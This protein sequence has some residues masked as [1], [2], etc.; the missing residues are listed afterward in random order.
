MNAFLTTAFALLSPIAAHACVDVSGT[1]LMGDIIAIH[2]EQRGCE[3]LTETWCDATGKS[4][5]AAPYTWPLNG[6]LVQAGG[7]P[8]HWASFQTEEDALHRVQ[9]WDSGTV[10][11][12]RQCW[13]KSMWY[14]KDVDQNLAVTFDLECQRPGGGY[15]SVTST[16]VWKKVP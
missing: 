12:G 9:L 4:C 1:Y 3:S 8:S 11:D 2:Y 6:E 14:R 13:W 16:E 5:D 10:K 7:N 15:D